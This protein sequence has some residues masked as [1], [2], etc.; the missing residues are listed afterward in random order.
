M[1]A[2]GPGSTLTII[3]VGVLL[4]ALIIFFK[5][6]R[7]VPQKM[8]YIVERLGKY[9][10]TL[11]AGFHILVPFIDRVSY[12]H[13]L[14]EQAVDVPPQDCITKD[15]IMVEVDG[16]LYMQ[17]IDPQRASY[18]IRDYAFASI[19]LAQ[20]T[21]RS[22]MGKLELDKTFEE[23]D[24][25]NGEIVDAV[26][27]ASDPWGVKVTRYEVK[28]IVPPKSIKDAMEK[29]MR[30]EREKRATIAESEGDREAKINRA[31]GEKREMIARSEGEKQKRIN[32]AEGRAVE[33]Q[34]VAEATAKGIR[35]IASA[36]NEKGGVNAVNL[37]IAE[38]Y[39]NEFGKLAGT[40][41]SIIIP[42]NLSDIAGM[43]K[44][45]ASVI[46]DQTQINDQTK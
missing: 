44:A 25:I 4:F 16:I 14:K 6:I 29:H 1:L 17:V 24:S 34:R 12:K 33:I 42:S 11:E 23:R 9:Y 3:L 43:I 37:R 22:V 35:E 13:T 36:I 30:A 8:A 10:T 31:E 40:N 2:L 46:K 28:N 39:L 7:I 32:E 15:N 18:G 38:Q 5:T 20:T 41:N 27:K 26:D 45:A 21:M 19:Q